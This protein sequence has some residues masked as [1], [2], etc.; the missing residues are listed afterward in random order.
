MPDNIETRFALCQ[1]TISNDKI[2]F[3]DFKEAFDTI[4]DMGYDGV[5]TTHKAFEEP[6]W[7]MN[8][9]KR[10]QIANAAEQAG[11]KII[12]GHWWL[13][14]DKYK[15]KPLHLMGYD[16]LTGEFNNDILNNTIE[17]GK[18]MLR[19]IGDV[20]GTIEVLGSPKQRSLPGGVHFADGR[21]LLVTYLASMLPI[22][23]KYG[24]TVCLEPLGPDESNFI[25]DDSSAHNI[26]D[27]L[28]SEYIAL[29]LDVK[30]M[31]SVG[32]P[33]EIIKR[34]NPERLKHFHVQEANRRASG[35]G[36]TPITSILCALKGIGYR[37]WVSEEH[38]I[39]EPNRVKLAGGACKY[40]NYCND[41][42][43]LWE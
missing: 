9:R 7:K 11:L 40:L 43:N 30:A 17:F 1:E 15:D 31:S 25:T 4:A 13:S 33:V 41:N 5:E 8:A 32:D 3:M 38:F 16:P 37:G 35:Q 39:Y 12:G 26:L 23:E 6:V 22:Q 29:L 14:E 18:N 20:G 36:T 28:D 42:V 24:I 2:G 21:G 10:E 34:N 19:F 27:C